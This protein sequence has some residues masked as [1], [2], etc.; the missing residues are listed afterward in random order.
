MVQ[1]TSSAGSSVTGSRRTSHSPTPVTASADVRPRARS[2]TI[3]RAA[4]TPARTARSRAARARSGERRPNEPERR[5][6]LLPFPSRVRRVPDPTRLC[7]DGYSRRASVDLRRS[8]R[9]SQG[10]RGNG[11][12]RRVRQAP[13]AGRAC[14]RVHQAPRR[15][16]P[17]APA[18]PARRRRAVPAGNHRTQPQAD[19]PAHGTAV[20]IGSDRIKVR[21]QVNTAAERPKF[22][23]NLTRRPRRPVRRL[24]RLFNRPCILVPHAS[25]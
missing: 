18:R 25:T 24:Q 12:L 16:A 2:A 15:S 13:P 14:V 4:H 3:G 10:P 20:P 21:L 5:H 17:S 9:A 23:E 6:H 11:R 22:S 7:T 1:G 19:G 8:R